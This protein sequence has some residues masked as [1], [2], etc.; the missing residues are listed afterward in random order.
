[1]GLQRIKKGDFSLFPTCSWDIETTNLAADF[2]VMLCATVKPFMGPCKTFRIDKYPLYARTKSDDRMLV[3]ALAKELSKY[4]IAIGYNTQRFDLPFLIGRL[5]AARC[6]V[7]LLSNIKHLD[8]IWAVRYRMRLRGASLAIASEHLETLDHKTPLTG[9]LWQR[10]TGG[11][12][13]AL[14]KI[15]RHNIQ[16]VKVLEQVAKRLTGLIDIKFSLIR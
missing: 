15:V 13:K 6:D 9:R 8:L 2:G 7:R 11:D 12:T 3:K 4:T 5:I 10:A 1:M 16:D 14:D